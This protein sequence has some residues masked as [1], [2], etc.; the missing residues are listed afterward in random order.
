VSDPAAASSHSP[1]LA[2]V[3]ATAV[4]KSEIALE[5]ARR[6]NGEI[7]SV[8][9]MQVYRGMDI[10]TAKPSFEQRSEI[11]HHLVDV[12]DITGSFDAAEFVQLAKQ[13]VKEIR[14][15]GHLPILC[16]GTGLYIRAFFDGLGAAPKGSPELRAELDDKPLDELLRELEQFDPATYETIDRRNRRRVTRA[17][18]VIRLTG[19]PHSVQ[20]A[21]WK[22]S[23]VAVNR[24]PCFGLVRSSGD[25]E[26]RIKARVDKMFAEG[27]VAET[28]KLLKAGLE[29]NRTA[30]QALGYRQVVE[31][32][33]GAR[34]LSETIGL[35]KIRTRQ[36]AKRQM[37]WFRRQLP[38]DWIQVK[39]AEST[40][41]I[42]EQVV[43]R[44]KGAPNQPWRNGLNLERQE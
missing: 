15:R 11:P 27:L 1:V 36:F 17:V 7:V 10:G 28:Q 34:S 33:Q 8:D 25:L 22:Q 18:E 41:D 20:R 32:L 43:Q 35:V 44:W 21:D 38:V 42:V 26:H 2:L 40:P 3:G 37:T 12:V 4:G 14:V 29:E 9:S 39:P 6:L 23:A 5:L 30:M 31:H 19:K 16:G 24:P 13:A